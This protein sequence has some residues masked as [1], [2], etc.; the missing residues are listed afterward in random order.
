MIRVSKSCLSILE[1]RYLNK[2]IQKQYLGM[3]PEVKKFES[4]LEKFFERKV[5]CVNSG[6][7]ALH[8]ALQAC[9][10]KNGDEVLVP[11]ITYVATYQAV[12]ATGAKPI[13]TFY[14]C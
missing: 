10:I 11:A 5:I 9:G 12:A 8:L 6:T 2:V 7:A 4:E 14:M 13:F 3:G 1:K